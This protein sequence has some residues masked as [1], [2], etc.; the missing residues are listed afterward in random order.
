MKVIEWVLLFCFS[1][2]AAA[3]ISFHFFRHPFLLWNE[4]SLF[5]HSNY[6]R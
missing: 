2:I 5:S 6:N 1:P 4:F 3:C